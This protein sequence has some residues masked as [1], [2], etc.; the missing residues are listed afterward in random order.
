MKHAT[1]GNADDGNRVNG[2][3]VIISHHIN[4]KLVACGENTIAYV[5]SVSLP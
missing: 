4:G 1:K 2:I 5:L 3:G